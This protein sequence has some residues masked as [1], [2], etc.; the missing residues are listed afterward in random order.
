MKSKEVYIQRF[1]VCLF[2][3]DLFNSFSNLYYYMCTI[4]L[5]NE[6]QTFTGSQDAAHDF[7]TLKKYKVPH[8]I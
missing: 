4:C 8:S 7:G 1:W 6:I 3:Q 5:K 2:K